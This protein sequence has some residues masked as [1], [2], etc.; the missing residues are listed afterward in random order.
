M[1]AGCWRPPLASLAALSRPKSGYLDE[2]EPPVAPQ[3]HLPEP[4]S[5][6]S[7]VGMFPQ[8][9]LQGQGMAEGVE[10]RQCLTVQSYIPARTVYKY[11]FS[12]IINN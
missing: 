9:S 8:F 3:L 1:G 7:Y 10:I 4:Q 11:K 6:P 12:Q 5:L 2:E